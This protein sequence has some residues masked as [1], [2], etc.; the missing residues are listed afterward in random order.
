MLIIYLSDAVKLLVGYLNQ[1]H[2]DI[3]LLLGW[4]SCSVFPG[5]FLLPRVI[6]SQS[7]EVLRFRLLARCRHCRQ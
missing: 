2:S 3:S 7:P 5:W 6:R 4:W 1:S